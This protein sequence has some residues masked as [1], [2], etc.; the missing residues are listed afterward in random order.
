MDGKLL[1]MAR[2]HLAEVKQKNTAEAHRRRREVYD[3]SPLMQQYDRALRQ[4]MAELFATAMDGSRDVHELEKR[5]LEIQANRANTLISLGYPANYLDEIVC[6]AQCR[7]TG[8]VM[9]K[10]CPCLKQQYE[11]EAAKSLSDLMLM[12]DERFES[13]HLGYYDD[14]INPATGVSPR[15][16]ME[17]VLAAC[18]TYAGHF[19]PGSI[20]LLFRGGPGLGKTFLSA[21]IARVVSEKG[22]SVVY[23]S[24]GD[25]VEAFEEKRFA[26]YE[27]SD[28]VARVE[29]ILSADLL[30]LDDLGTEI[31][32]NSANAVLYSI[33]NKRLAAGGSMIISTNL[34][35]EELR[36]RYTPQ[37][38]SRIEGSF[39]TLEFRGRDIRAI[40]K[41]LGM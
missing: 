36:R 30:I 13:F 26:R 33:L 19:S 8:Y 10:M 5:S 39:E 3:R 2:D 7:D 35:A 31:P 29:R 28:A 27:D 38:V 16:C 4:I 1:K 11:R 9:G 15:K 18:K 14:V 24:T 32:G 22:Y 17:M 12:G 41:Q 23:E 40:K 20:N 21:C 34:S 25:A 37:I 6:C